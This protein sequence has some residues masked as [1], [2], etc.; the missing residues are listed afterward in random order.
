MSGSA[1]ILL[2]A[3]GTPTL[4]VG[5]EV[6]TVTRPT[7][8]APGRIS[9]SDPFATVGPTFHLRVA[10]AAPANRTLRVWRFGTHLVVLGPP[11]AL[12][13]L[14]YTYTRSMP[15]L[16]WGGERWHATPGVIIDGEVPVGCARCAAIWSYAVGAPGYALVWDT[17]TVV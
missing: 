5:V 3:S 10:A 14:E 4:T 15:E 1:L 9:S 11:Q 12:L 8:A 6:Y 7:S 2:T 13:H 16:F 17:V